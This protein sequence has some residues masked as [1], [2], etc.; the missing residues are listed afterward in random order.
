[1][2]MTPRTA[3]PHRGKFTFEDLG[4]FV[5]RVFVQ[6]PAGIRQ[7]RFLVLLHLLPQ[8]ELT[9]DVREGN[10]NQNRAEPVSRRPMRDRNRQQIRRR[11]RA[12]H[13]KPYRRH[14][15]TAVTDYLEQPLEMRRVRDKIDHRP[16]G[17]CRRNHQKRLQQQQCLFAL[18]EQIRQRNGREQY[19]RQVHQRRRNAVPINL[20]LGLIDWI[21]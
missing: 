5:K 21:S 8:I 14:K 2:S 9:I 3:G 16:Q 19:D 20:S 11:L 18:A 13:G 10:D 12:G 15:I 1:M 17:D 7:D 4:L 6:F